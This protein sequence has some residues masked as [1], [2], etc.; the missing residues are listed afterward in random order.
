MI[1]Q[2]TAKNLPPTTAFVK[3][4]APWATGKKRLSDRLPKLSLITLPAL[5]LTGYTGQ[6]VTNNTWFHFL[7]IQK[8]CSVFLDM[9]KLTFLLKAFS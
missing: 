7:E 5:E 2:T 1:R 3:A 8:Y 4:L 9:R 6:R